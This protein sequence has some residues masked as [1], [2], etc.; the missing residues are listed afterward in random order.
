MWKSGEMVSRYFNIVLFAMGEL[1]REPVYV[2]LLH[3]LK[4]SA[5]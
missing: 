4:L 5:Y 3:M 1:A 2:R